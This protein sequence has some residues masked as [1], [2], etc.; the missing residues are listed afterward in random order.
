MKQA[1]WMLTLGS[2]V[3]LLGCASNS[4][5]DHA[6]YYAEMT[7]KT[8]PN[9]TLTDLNGEKVSLASLKGKPVMVCFWAVG[10]PPCREEAPYLS[11]LANDHADKN[12]VVLGVNA[13]NE[14]K[15]TVRKFV[16]DQKLSHRILLDGAEVFAQYG[17]EAVPAVFW[18]D[19][20]GMIADVKVGFEGPA[21]LRDRTRSL[22][23]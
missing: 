9:F 3:G 12:L 14:T 1:I 13:W 22:V 21:S 8:A 19:R 10:C 20:D 15:S 16:K 5:N 11:Q 7:G 18:I 17:G 4:K 23:N 6:Q 2:M